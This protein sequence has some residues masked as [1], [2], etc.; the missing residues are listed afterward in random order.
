MAEAETFG[1][2]PRPR[3]GENLSRG[4]FAFSGAFLC[5]VIFA[6]NPANHTLIIR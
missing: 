2:R 3:F 4:L 1:G 5:L 6:S